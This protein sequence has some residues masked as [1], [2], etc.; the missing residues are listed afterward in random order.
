MAIDTI[1]ETHADEDTIYR[2]IPNPDSEPGT[3]F[4]GGAVLQ[5]RDRSSKDD[6]WNDHFFVSPAAFSDMSEMFARAADMT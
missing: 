6:K 5:W 1:F 3:G 4:R 2:L